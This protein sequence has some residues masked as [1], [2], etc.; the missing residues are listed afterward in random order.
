MLEIGPGVYTAPGMTRAV[1]DRIW[2]VMEDWHGTVADEGILMTWVDNTVP[3]RQA[4]RVLGLPRTDLVNHNGVYLA[5]RDLP[6]R[7]DSTLTS[8][9]IPSSTV[10]PSV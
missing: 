7:Q 10:A 5:R 4:I 8:E 3:G 9:Q 1:R 2:E 6:P